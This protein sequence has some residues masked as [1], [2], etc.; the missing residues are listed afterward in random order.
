MKNPTTDWVRI[1]QA[2]GA[3]GY[4]ILSLQSTLQLNSGDQIRLALKEG[5][6]HDGI[7]TQNTIGPHSGFSGWLIEEDIV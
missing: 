3:G 5:V 2:Y 1:Q 6:I 4:H 7:H